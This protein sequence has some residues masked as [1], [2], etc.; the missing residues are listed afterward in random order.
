MNQNNKRY[1]RYKNVHVG[2]IYYVN[3]EP[4]YGLEFPGS[5]LA[6]I[7]KKNMDRDTVI[8]MPLTSS[9]TGEGASEAPLPKYFGKGL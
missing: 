2:E 9:K 8:V 1:V 7:L 6:V 5:H 4:V 3:F